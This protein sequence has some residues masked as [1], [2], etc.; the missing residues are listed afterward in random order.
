MGVWPVGWSDTQRPQGGNMAVLIELCLQVGWILV[1][2]MP[3]TN[4]C[5]LH[6]S[7]TSHQASLGQLMPALVVISPSSNPEPGRLKYSLPQ[8]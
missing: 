8:T 1:S 2:D 3:L 5:P 7:V 4:L 6:K